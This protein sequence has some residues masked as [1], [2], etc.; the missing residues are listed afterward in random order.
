MTFNFQNSAFPSSPGVYLM[1]D[2]AGKIIYI[3]KAKNLKNRVGSYF[4]NKNNDYKTFY[5]L[6][7]LKHIDYILAV[8]EREALVI[9]RE[10]IH[11]FQPFYNRMW[12]D[13][14]S[15][16][17]IKIS[18]KE[19]FPRISSTRKRIKDGS[20]YYGPYP[21][22]GDMG[23]FVRWLRDF[24][25][26]RQCNLNFTEQLLPKEDKI[27]TCFYLHTN[28]C[29]APCVGKVSASEYKKSLRPL[30]LLLNGKSKS[31]LLF[32]Q[33][34]M[35]EAST[36][37]EFEKAASLRDKLK[38]IGAISERFSVRELKADDLLYATGDKDALLELK[39]VLKLNKLPYIIEGIDISN[40]QGTHPVGSLVR[41]I[42]GKADKS[43]YRRYGIKS[44]LG[45]ND[46]AMI[47]EVVR[48]RYLKFIK[49]KNSL[50]DLILIDGGPAQLS[51]AYNALK[52]T[53]VKCPIIS[54]AKRNEEVFLPE[55]QNS[56]KLE[57]S[58]LA[59]QLLQRVRDEAHRFAVA[60]H[61]A[62]REKIAI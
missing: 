46:V 40:L 29:P 5:L 30:K 41:F 42:A 25:G 34:Q 8:S 11:K 27:K 33:K 58:S 32:W 49:D 50:P 60:F 14:K 44:V 2:G 56:I 19:D 23:R 37:L 62:R 36:K 26:I 18:N 39:T 47:A 45:Q 52:D 24:F 57:R 17:L 7:T 20:S 15:Y 12:K 10:L 4:K 28:K 55:S 59:L 51:F 35:A 31:L 1:R 38:T 61:R 9:E 16:P 13:D 3:G 43:G 21:N 48:R 54:L 6:K 22:S 53:G